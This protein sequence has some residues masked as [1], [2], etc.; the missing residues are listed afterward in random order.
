MKDRISEYIDGEGNRE[1][2]EKLLKDDPEAKEYFEQLSFM[3]S[4]LSEMHVQSPDIPDKVLQKE[5][6]HGSVFRYRFVFASILAVAIVSMIFFS[7]YDLN[8]NK[9]APSSPPT[10]TAPNGQGPTFGITSAAPELTVSIGIRDD[11]A[12]LTVLEQYGQITGDEIRGEG[13][14]DSQIKIAGPQKVLYYNISANKIPELVEAIKNI[15]GAEV[16][17]SESL[18]QESSEIEIIVNIYEK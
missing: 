8:L 6:S 5:R 17:I 16:T 1:E 13:G 10:L 4:T 3:K 9:R 14:G 12:L 11:S 2:L 7:V 15:Q 18:P